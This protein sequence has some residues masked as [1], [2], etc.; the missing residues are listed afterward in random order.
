M[1]GHRSFLVLGGGAA[2]IVSLIKGGME[3]SN[4]NYA[5]QQAV[6][7]KGKATT[8]VYGGAISVT[9]AQ[10]PST[11]ITEW[12]LDSRK[13]K[14]GIIVVLDNENLPL[15]RIIFEDAVCTGFE[16]NYTQTGDSYTS[17]KLMIEAQKLIVGDGIDFDNEWNS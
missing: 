6:D 1:F 3:I 14:D 13:H 7:N 15:E 11:E 9:L 12:A 17:T 5:F 8:R 4:C 16:I 10:L 2:D